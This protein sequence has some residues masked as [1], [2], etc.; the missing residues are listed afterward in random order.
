MFDNGVRMNGVCMHRLDGWSGNLYHSEI[1]DV[2]C[3]VALE[4]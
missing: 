3:T 2:S 4:D 1:S